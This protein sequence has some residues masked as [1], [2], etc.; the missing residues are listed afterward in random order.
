MPVFCTNES[1]NLVILTSEQSSVSLVDRISMETFICHVSVMVGALV[2]MVGVIVGLRYFVGS[3]D[4]ALEG[5]IVGKFVGSFVGVTDGIFV[6]LFVG[7]VVVSVGYSVGL[8]VI[9][10]ESGQSVIFALA[11]PSFP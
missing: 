5:L 10:H 1:P 3:S 11:E 7:L 8:A 9:F 4:G 6:G 2:T